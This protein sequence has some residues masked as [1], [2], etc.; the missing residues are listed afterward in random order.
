MMKVS[1]LFAGGAVAMLFGAAGALSGCDE[2][3]GEPDLPPPPA[4]EEQNGAQDP[5]PLGAPPAEEPATQDQGMNDQPALPDP[6][7]GDDG[8]NAGGGAY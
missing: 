5:D 2:G 1:K 4:V 6:E 3:M 8:D 7:E